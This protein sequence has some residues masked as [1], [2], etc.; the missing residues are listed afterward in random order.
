M[1]SLSPRSLERLAKRRLLR[2][3]VTVERDGGE[4]FL[5]ED[6]RVAIGTQ[7]GFNFFTTYRRRLRPFEN[8]DNVYDVL[9]GKI[10]RYVRDWALKEH[11]KK[12]AGEKKEQ[13][14]RRDQA[15]G[16]LL[17]AVEHVQKIRSTSK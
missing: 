13:T 6:V 14:Y 3:G 2:H 16:E 1:I 7:Y 17:E 11:L 10:N 15:M 8:G 9:K 4:V 5:C 12:K